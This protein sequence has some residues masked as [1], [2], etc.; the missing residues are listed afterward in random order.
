MTTAPGRSVHV[1][2]ETSELK[3]T[4]RELHTPDPL[5]RKKS[6]HQHTKLSGSKSVGSE[7]TLRLKAVNDISTKHLWNDECQ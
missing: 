5:S 7:V 6:S 1:D 2:F 4:G 3:S